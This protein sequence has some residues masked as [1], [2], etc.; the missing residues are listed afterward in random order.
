V[1]E[2]FHLFTLFSGVFSEN[3]KVKGVFPY[4]EFKKKDKTFV[5]FV[6]SSLTIDPE[7]VSFN[8]E[9]LFNGD[10]KLGDNVNQVLNDNWKEVFDDVIQD[11]IE[12]FNQILISVFNNLFSK[13]SLE[14]AF[15]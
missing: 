2:C 11:Y 8:F 10:K 9:N 1:S 13:V 14:D 6:S 5:K 12:V 3:V 7:L 15:D 4:E